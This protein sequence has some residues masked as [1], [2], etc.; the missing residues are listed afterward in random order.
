M[1]KLFQALSDFAGPSN[2]RT[3]HQEKL[4]S[5]L[6]GFIGIL[7]VTSVTRH[8][9]GADDAT[10]VIAS[11]G[12]SAVLLFAVPHGPLSQP[13]ALG[14]GHLISA[15]IGVSCY[16]L[17]PDMYLAAPAAVGVSITT[18]YYLRCMHPPGGATALSAVISGPSVHELGYQFMVTPVLLNVVIIFSVALA[19]NFLFPWRRYPSMLMHYGEETNN[20]HK[21]TLEGLGRYQLESALRQM[22]Q[23]ID[24]SSDDLEQIFQL[25]RKQNSEGQLQINQLKLGCYY[26]NGEIGDNWSVRQ[27]VDESDDRE[28]EEGLIIYKVVA[29]KGRPGSGTISRSDFTQWAK[30]EVYLNERSWERVITPARSEA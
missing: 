24:I 8:F 25:A 9:L 3:S 27:I 12:A 22:D 16:Q 13:W 18:M 5:G 17:I 15:F 11:M 2:N 14:C 10:V 26:S 29:G 6:G 30:Y 7:F 28:S 1:K 21:P 4:I 20:E 23:F 19:F